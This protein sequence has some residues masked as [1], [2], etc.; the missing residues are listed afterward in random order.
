MSS[1]NSNNSRRVLITGATGFIGTQLV[2]LMASQQPEWYLVATDVRPSDEVSKLADQFSIIDVRDQ[3]AL[4]A[5]L[6][7]E[8][9]DTLVHLASIV[10]PPTGM[11][12]ETLYEI[13]VEGTRN[14]LDAALQANVEQFVVTTS[15][16]AY[17]YHADNPEWLSEADPV[18]GNDSFAYS[19]HKRIVEELLRDYRQQ[20]PELQ[21]LVLRPGTVLGETVN[22]QITN[23][24]DQICIVGVAGCR[25]PFV[26]IW[27]QDLVC[28]IEQGIE[29]RSQGIYNVAGDG[30]LSMAQ[31]AVKLNKPY[32][33]L[34]SW[35]IK[36]VLS[37][38]K[39]LR[40]SQ[41]G[42]EQVKFI[43]YRPVL[44]NRLLKSEFGYIPQY[45]SEE[46]F[47]AYLASRKT[48]QEVA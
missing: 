13:D 8:R 24:F 42:P 46:A 28:I 29:R 40:L 44:D 20:H 47:D 10:V 5:L 18:R 9:I 27:D 30:A 31:L 37:I 17:G 22:N 36:G 39:P 45:T 34:P 4:I 7:Q 33:P 35:L 15:G 16:A 11:S 43:S 38:L 41:Y 48:R 14:A 25:S 23:L 12:R 2:R 21:Q 1:E 32:L 26:F 19:S 3:K 6:Q